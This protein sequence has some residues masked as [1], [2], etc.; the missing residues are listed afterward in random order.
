MKPDDPVPLSPEAD[1]SLA[2]VPVFQSLGLPSYRV[3]VE[4][5]IACI[6]APPED[7]ARLLDPAVRSV[8]LTHGKAL[9]YLFVTLDME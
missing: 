1:P 8:L 2:W 7:F 9:G 6:A 3:R 5:R 4:G